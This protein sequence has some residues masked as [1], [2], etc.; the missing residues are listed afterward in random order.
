MDQIINFRNQDMPLEFLADK[1][2]KR[3]MSDKEVRALRSKIN[4]K[5]PLAEGAKEKVRMIP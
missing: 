5:F 4:L 3:F 2:G 1:N